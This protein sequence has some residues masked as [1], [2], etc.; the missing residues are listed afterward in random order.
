MGVVPSTVV[1]VR[2]ILATGFVRYRRGGFRVMLSVP[3]VMAYMAG[4]VD[5]SDSWCP[6]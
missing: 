2:V 1:V 3:N 5:I 6:R 4:D